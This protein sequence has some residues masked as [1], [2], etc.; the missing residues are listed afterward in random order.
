LNLP[1]KRDP[2]E[3]HSHS[4][5][6]FSSLASKP[7]ISTLPGIGHFYFALTSLF[8]CSLFACSCG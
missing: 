3:N 1:Q 7:D 6:S 8:A 5:L 2:L 4:K